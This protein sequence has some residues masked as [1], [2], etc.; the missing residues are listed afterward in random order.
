MRPIRQIVLQPSP[1]CN[2]DCT[3][4]YL[5][6]RQNRDR[7]SI[8][9]VQA[10]ICRVIES[11][12]YHHEVDIRWHAGEPLAV[13]TDFYEEAFAVV[14][15]IK[16]EDA[17]FR[18]SMQTNATLVDDRWCQFVLDNDIRLGVSIDGPDFI[19]DKYRKTRSGR[20]TFKDVMRGVSRLREAGIAF[21]AIAVVT[22]F[23]CDYPDQVHDF[24]LNLGAVS[25]AFN[26]EET[27]GVHKSQ[28]AAS[29]VFLSKYKSFLRRISRLNEQSPIAIRELESMKRAIRSASDEHF[30]SMCTPLGIVSVDS[31]GAMSTF[32]PELLGMS[33]EQF[34]TFC[35][36]NVQH[37]TISD[38][39]KDPNF[40]AVA[41]DIARGVSTCKQECEY[42]A[43]CGGGSPSNKLFEN[44]TFNSSETSYCKA[45]IKIP[46]DLVLDD[47]ESELV[48]ESGQ[49]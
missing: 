1:F 33:H 49:P 11:G 43:F 23:T 25:I 20:G 9:I 44:G 36:G 40:V 16:P 13:P 42:F 18:H 39:A 45:R 27:E 30:N 35:Y 19:H 4:C 7:I 24:F 10:A 14:D 5:P 46:L 21:E 8:D 31:G 32:S 2:L 47:M 12:L 28:S 48:V 41:A 29:P 6:D 22:E 3:Y 37:N 17:T 38:I 15:E 34:P 26:I